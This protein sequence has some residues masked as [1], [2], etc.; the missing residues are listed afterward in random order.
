MNSQK[1]V[2]GIQKIVV[3][4]LGKTCISKLNTESSIKMKIIFIIKT[5]IIFFILLKEN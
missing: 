5:P 1:L 4:E 3:C 2:N